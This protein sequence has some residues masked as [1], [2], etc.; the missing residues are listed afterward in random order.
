MDVKKIEIDLC[1]YLS[2]DDMRTIAIEEFRAVARQKSKEDFQRI[3]DNA[4]FELVRREVDE[5]FDGGMAETVKS[6]AYQVIGEMTTFTVFKKKDAWGTEESRA[7]VH[8]Q[9]AMDDAKPL[10]AERVNEIIRGMSNGALHDLIQQQ[11]AVAIIEK[12]TAPIAALTK[13]AK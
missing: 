6:R 2:H 4:A 13:E 9:S 7:Y 8:L 3:L 10:I 1:A 12:L 11:I 5:L